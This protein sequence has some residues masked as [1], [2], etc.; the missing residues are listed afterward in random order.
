[1]GA[2]GTADTGGL[3]CALGGT[4]IRLA[5]SRQDPGT[6]RG[7]CVRTPPRRGGRGRHRSGTAQGR[8]SA[9]HGPQ[10]TQLWRCTISDRG[11]SALPAFYPRERLSARAQPGVGAADREPSARTDALSADRSSP[12]L[13]YVALPHLERISF[14]FTRRSRRSWMPACAGMTEKSF[15]A[16]S[17]PRKRESSI[18]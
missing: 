6:D 16:M 9:V 1:M 18:W 17:F 10:G 7:L 8:S 15:R 12:E 13:L 14:A 3:P 5:A 2:T 11:R 4:A